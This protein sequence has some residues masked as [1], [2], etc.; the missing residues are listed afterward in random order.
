MNGYWTFSKN[1]VLINKLDDYNVEITNKMR[2][3]KSAI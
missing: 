3:L 2:M 1:T